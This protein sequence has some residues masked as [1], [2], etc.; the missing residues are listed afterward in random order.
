MVVSK[1]RITFVKPG[2]KDDV[3]IETKGVGSPEK[4]FPV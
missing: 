4:T 1:D 3:L 2:K